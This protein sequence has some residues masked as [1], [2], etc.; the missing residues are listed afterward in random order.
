MLFDQLLIDGA[1]LV[2]ESAM[3]FLYT[4]LITLQFRVIA[5]VMGTYNERLASEITIFV[6]IPF[7]RLEEIFR[8]I[9]FVS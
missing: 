5:I 2:I 3:A 4:S 9:L 7:V 6:L 1:T 8:H